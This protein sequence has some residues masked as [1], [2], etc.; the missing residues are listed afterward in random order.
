MGSC[1]VVQEVLGH[2]LALLD[3]GGTDLS[4]HLKFSGRI[5]LG[6]SDGGVGLGEH[7]PLLS[8]GAV[9]GRNSSISQHVA[10]SKSAEH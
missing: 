9:G 5:S 10:R 4:W 6:D 1:H 7:G 2:S 3:L 8:L